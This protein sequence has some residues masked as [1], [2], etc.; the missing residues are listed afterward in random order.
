[1]AVTSRSR[2]SIIRVPRKWKRRQ[3]PTRRQLQARRLSPVLLLRLLL[4]LLLRLATPRRKKASLPLPA[5]V[6]RKLRLR[7]R[8]KAARSNQRWHVRPPPVFA[9]AARTCLVL[10]RFVL[11]WPA[12]LSRSSSVSATRDPSTCSRVT[13]PASGSWTRSRRRSARAFAATRG[14]RARSA[15]RSCRAAR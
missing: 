10:G 8:R 4:V 13:T 3:P 1:M 15:A 5:P 6:L 7:R 9:G 2:R 14:F 12:L 11:L